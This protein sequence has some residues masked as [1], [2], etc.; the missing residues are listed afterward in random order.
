V[1]RPDELKETATKM[2]SRGTTIT[3]YN[4]ARIPVNPMYSQRRPSVALDEVVFF[5]IAISKFT[6]D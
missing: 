6:G 4:L 2:S 3:I 1:P 5:D